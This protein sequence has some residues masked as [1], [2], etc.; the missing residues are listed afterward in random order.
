[1]N[2]ILFGTKDEYSLHTSEVLA[3]LLWPVHKV[4]CPALANLYTLKAQ[5]LKAYV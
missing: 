5:I 1:M 3:C 4:D 2:G